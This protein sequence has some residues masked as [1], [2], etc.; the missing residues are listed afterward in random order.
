[1]SDPQIISALIQAIG[2]IIATTIA[3]RVAS[4]IGKKFADRERLVKLLALASRD[5]E[6]LLEVERA[7]SKIHIDSGRGSLI[8]TARKAAKLAGYSW[9]G[10]FV[11]SRSKNFTQ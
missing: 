6:F 4:L 9:S 10:Q 11:P 1:M 2:G 8:R 7:H 5:V 3:A